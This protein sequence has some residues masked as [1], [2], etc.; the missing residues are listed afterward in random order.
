MSLRKAMLPF[1]PKSPDFAGPIAAAEHK[2][3]RENGD[4]IK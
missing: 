3:S 2:G 4:V 1:S